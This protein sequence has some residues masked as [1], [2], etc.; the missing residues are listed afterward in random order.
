MLHQSKSNFQV[1]MVLYEVLRLYTPLTSVH[2]KAVKPMDL[3]GVRYPAGMLFMVPFLCI[4]HDK[5]VW[6]ADADE[7]R[8]GR[9]ANGIFKASASDDAPAFFP[10]G[11]GQRTCVGQNFAMLEAK[12]GLAMILQRFSFELSS[13]YAHAPFPVGLLHPEHGAQIMLRRLP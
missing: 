9:F 6:G 10:F 1:T 4:H 2:R 8:P 3:G 5:D 7:F 12:M 13:S 11:W